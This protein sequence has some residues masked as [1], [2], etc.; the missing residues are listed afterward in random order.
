MLENPYYTREMHGPYEVFDLGGFVL[1][2]GHIPYGNTSPHT[3]RYG[4][5]NEAR[6]NS[7]TKAN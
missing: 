7:S 5:Y 4:E 1:E 3:R 6:D 2:E